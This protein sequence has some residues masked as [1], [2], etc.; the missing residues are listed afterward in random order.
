MDDEKFDEEQINF[1]IAMSKLSCIVAAKFHTD[2]NNQSVSSGVVSPGVVSPDVVSPDVLAPEATPPTGR[3]LV[4]PVVR[5]R[6]VVQCEACHLPLGSS[7]EMRGHRCGAESASSNGNK[8]A[9]VARGFSTDKATQKKTRVNNL[10]KVQAKP[11]EVLLQN[12]VGVVKVGDGGDS[13]YV[14]QQDHKHKRTVR[15]NLVGVLEVGDDGDGYY[16]V[17]DHK[18]KRTVRNKVVS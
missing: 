13:Y 12:L 1:D 17:E 15:K 4:S 2:N 6:S 3:R 18:H 16:V 14:V 8:L 10:V 7:A 5:R 9:P 11:V